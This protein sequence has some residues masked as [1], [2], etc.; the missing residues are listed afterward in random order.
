ML[1]TCQEMQREREEVGGGVSQGGAETLRKEELRRLHRL[2][3]FNPACAC[4][5]AC[6]TSRGLQIIT[7][8]GPH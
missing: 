8:E 4:V 1:N 7:Q 2:A 3:V 6:A 5:R